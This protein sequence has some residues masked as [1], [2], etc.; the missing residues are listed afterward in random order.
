MPAA[1]L[2][3]SAAVWLSIVAVVAGC[4][5]AVDPFLV[6][7]RH[8]SIVGYL[9]QAADT[10]WVRVEALRDGRHI[11]SPRPPGESVVLEHLASGWSERLRDSLFVWDGVRGYNYW[12]VRT[13]EPLETYR[14][15]VVGSGGES[16]TATTT[17]PDAFPEP[18]LSSTPDLRGCPS[19]RT[20][21]PMHVTIAGV[22]RLV[23][24]NAIYTLADGSRRTVRH[25]HRS[26]KIGAAVEAELNWALDVGVCMVGVVRFELEV[27]AGSSDWP[28]S[29]GLG[30]ES[31]LLPSL[32]TN[33]EGGTGYFGG[34]VSR[35]LDVPIARLQP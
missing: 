7:D 35:R 3:C 31:D 6:S 25:L 1:R 18:R 21:P 12:A 22:G 15:T 23:A 29:T 24:L 19:T 17:L 2:P 16:A 13:V 8:F 33:V 30:S 14:I 28:E 32:A 4:E 34:V 20:Q 9:H 26:K 5:T 11:G 27:A 10:Q